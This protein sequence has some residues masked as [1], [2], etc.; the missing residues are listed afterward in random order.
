MCKSYDKFMFKGIKVQS[1]FESSISTLEWEADSKGTNDIYLEDIVCVAKLKV[2]VAIYCYL[3]GS[4]LLDTKAK[5]GSLLA[6]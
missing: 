1:I 6:S 3:F 4:F 2:V 5:I